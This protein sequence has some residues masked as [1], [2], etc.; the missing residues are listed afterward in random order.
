MI[1]LIIVQEDLGQQIKIE[2]LAYC[3]T[4]ILVSVA[5]TLRPGGPYS[6]WERK[7]RSFYLR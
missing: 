4:K 7:E 2:K 3:G 1:A 5:L 6:Q